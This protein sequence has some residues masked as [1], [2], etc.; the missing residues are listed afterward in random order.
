MVINIFLKMSIAGAILL[1]DYFPESLIF[2]E[3]VI[4]FMRTAAMNYSA[5]KKFSVMI[6]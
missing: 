6:I 1:N 2:L 3:H 5:S 4:F